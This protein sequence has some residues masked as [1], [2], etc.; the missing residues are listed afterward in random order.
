MVGLLAELE[1]SWLRSPCA[2]GYSL[3]QGLSAQELVRGNRVVHRNKAL[4]EWALDRFPAADGDRKETE[5][6]SP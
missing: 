6:E 3:S 1:E 4:P 2:H 5:K